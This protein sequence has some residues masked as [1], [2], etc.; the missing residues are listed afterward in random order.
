MVVQ[1]RRPE[2]SPARAIPK[3]TSRVHGSCDPSLRHR[4]QNPERRHSMLQFC[5]H[6]S[7]LVFVAYI[8]HEPD[9]AEG[10]DPSRP[11]HS[12][13][14]FPINP[15]QCGIVYENDLGD[16]NNRFWYFHAISP[17][18][19]KVWAGN[20]VINTPNVAFDRCID[21]PLSSAE[22]PR[23]RGFRRFD[24][25]DHDDFTVNLRP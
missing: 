18:D 11:W 12:L 15:G 17:A 5:N 2:Q 9:C 20:I 6:H 1:S 3:R 10:P 16:V 24:V 25:G 4:Y 21:G 23:A 22:D 14:W 8:F 7:R 19:G 13:G